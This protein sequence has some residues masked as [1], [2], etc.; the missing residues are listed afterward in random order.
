[1]GDAVRI[2]VAVAIPLGVPQ[3]CVDQTR[4]DIKLLNSAR[5]R[6]EAP[7][8]HAKIVGKKSETEEEGLEREGKLGEAKGKLGEA[9]GSKGKR[10]RGS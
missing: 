1:M 3:R 2:V 9:K 8:R 6:D 4:R 5:W 10:R 7:R